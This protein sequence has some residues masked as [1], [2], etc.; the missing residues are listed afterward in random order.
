MVGTY[1][2]MTKHNLEAWESRTDGWILNGMIKDYHEKAYGELMTMAGKVTTRLFR[3]FK[4][5]LRRKE[6]E[7]S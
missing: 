2:Q 1:P 4:R 3:A 5:D 7:S 6:I